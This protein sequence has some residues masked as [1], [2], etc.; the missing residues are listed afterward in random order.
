LYKEL[1]ESPETVMPGGLIHDDLCIV[2]GVGVEPGSIVSLHVDAA[3]A[4]VPGERFVATCVIMGELRAG[5]EVDAPPGIMD[6]VAI[7]SA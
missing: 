7:P 4:T 5:A 3:V 1:L 2:V 6:E